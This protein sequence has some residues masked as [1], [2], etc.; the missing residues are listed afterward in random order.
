MDQDA[1]DDLLKRLAGLE[2]KVDARLAELK[3][4]TR[5]QREL[6]R[7]QW[8]W[9]SDT[10]SRTW[11]RTICRSSARL[12]WGNVRGTCKNRSQVASDLKAID[13]SG[14]LSH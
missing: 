3:E 13:C 1:Y 6:N 12:S 7:Q 2:I 11:L 14:T 4:L 5:A 10:N 9:R 8:L